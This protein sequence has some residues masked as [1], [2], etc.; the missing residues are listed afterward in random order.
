MVNNYYKENAYNWQT[1]CDILFQQ[2]WHILFSE[3][4][5]SLGDIKN[6]KI[7]DAGCGQGAFYN[8]IKNAQYYGIDISNENIK[9]A[10]N[11]NNNNNFIVQNILK[12]EYSDNYFDALVSIEV[13]E[14]LT[15]EELDRF[16]YEIK[17]ITKKG[18]TIVITTPNLYYLWGLIPWS[19]YPIRRRLTFSKFIKG[20]L[21]G[22]VNENYN[23]S[24]H[25]YRFKPIFLRKRISKIRLKK[26]GTSTYWYNN[27]AIHGIF[28][29]TQLSLLNWSNIFKSR[30]ILL[31]SQ[32][33]II[34]K[35]NKD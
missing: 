23:I 17:R 26:I 25:H 21:H 20:I 11:I 33:V 32:L 16:L 5:K 2:A 7:L 28:S 13:I 27:R 10:K 35:N 9:I 24:A 4:Y 1:N 22:Y 14:H 8:Y 30:Y 31:G 15:I 3:V 12:T 18:S 29:K 34:C 6:K 19:F